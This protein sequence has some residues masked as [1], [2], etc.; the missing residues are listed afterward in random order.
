MCPVQ[1]CKQYLPNLT[2]IV[3]M[4]NPIHVVGSLG[5]SQNQ[6]RPKL[7]NASSFTCFLQVLV[8]TMA[9]ATPYF[10]FASCTISF[11]LLQE[12]VIAANSIVIWVE[13]TKHL[14]QISGQFIAILE[15]VQM[16]ARHDGKSRNNNGGKTIYLSIQCWPIP[17]CKH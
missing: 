15:K 12:N 9:T 6:I 16:K 14:V 8:T 5:F 1:T 3:R 2:P 4:F 13:V 7:S 11:Q 10:W 17:C